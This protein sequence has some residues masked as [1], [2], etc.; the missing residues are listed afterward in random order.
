L[1]REVRRLE[2]RSVLKINTWELPACLHDGLEDKA[3]KGR[4][5]PWQKLPIVLRWGNPEILAT[6]SSTL[7]L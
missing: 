2:A 5:V 4:Q 6:V 3:A 7:K 1:D